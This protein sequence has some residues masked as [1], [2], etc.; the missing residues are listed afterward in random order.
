MAG[1]LIIIASQLLKEYM[2]WI[3]M[4]MGVV[5]I[6]I[7]ALMLMGKNFSF[8]LHIK[9]TSYKVESMEAFVFGIAYAIGAL[10][11]LILFGR[12]PLILWRIFLV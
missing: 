8:T 12:G 6:L 4:A 7:G 1:L 2:K 10:G 9:S 5:L 11:C 3:A